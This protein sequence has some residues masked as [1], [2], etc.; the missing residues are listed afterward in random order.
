[1]AGITQ[2]QG[3]ARREAL[4]AYLRTYYRQKKY[5]PQIKEMSEALSLSRTVVVWHLQK[6]RESKQLDYED[7]NMARTLRLQ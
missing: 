2:P 6:L 4:L 7:G 1:M 5:M 3:E